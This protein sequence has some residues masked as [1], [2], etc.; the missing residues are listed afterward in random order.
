MNKLVKT[1]VLI[2]TTATLFACEKVEQQKSNSDKVVIE[3]YL[4]AGHKASIKVTKELEY[5]S[6]DTTIQPIEGLDILLTNNSVSEHLADAGDGY[7]ESNTMVMN[8]GEKYSITFTYDNRIV[9]AETTIPAKPEEYATTANSFSIPTFNPYSGEP[10]SFPDPITLSWSNQDKNYYLVVVK[11]IER[12]PE[13]IFDST[14]FELKKIFRNKP[15][16]TDNYRL[17]MRSFNYY[18]THQIILY[19]LNSEYVSL[20]D[21]NGTSSLNIQTPATNVKGGLGIFTGLNS[22]TI[23]V[24]VYN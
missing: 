19:N 11:N 7:Y 8:V 21:D 10:P 16:Q 3:G 14:R 6:G 1:F 15:I 13:A 22:D 23:Y 2:T 24:E 12:N 9:S 5:E 18:G 17:D 4:F 20:Y